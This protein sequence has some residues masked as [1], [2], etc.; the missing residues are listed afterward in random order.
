MKFSPRKAICRFAFAALLAS[1]GHAAPADC[2]SG[3]TC[4]AADLA[5]ADEAVK[6]TNAQLDAVLPPAGRVKL[7]AAQARFFRRRAHVCRQHGGGMDDSCAVRLTRARLAVLNSQAAAPV[8]PVGDAGGVDSPYN[9][10]NGP[11]GGDPYPIRLGAL[12]GAF[13]D[14]VGVLASAPFV[15]DDGPDLKLIPP[16]ATQLQ[17]GLNDDFAADH[18]GGLVISVI[19][20]PGGARRLHGC[21]V[22]GGAVGPVCQNYPAWKSGLWRPPPGSGALHVLAVG[23]GGGGGMANP[24]TGVGGA[25]GGSGK[26]ITGTMP[27]PDGP[28]RIVVG[29]GGAGARSAKAGSM[30]GTGSVIGTLVARGGWGGQPGCGGSADGPGGNSGGGGGGGGTYQ[31]SYDAG[32]GGMGGTGGDGGAGLPPTDI[33]AGFNGSDGGAGTAFPIFDFSDLTFG[34]GPGGAGGSFG[35]GGLT[36]SG[37]SCAGGGGG[38]GGGGGL[39]IN[40]AGPH[41][42]SGTGPELLKLCGAPALN[43]Q[44][45]LG[46]GAGGGGAGAGVAGPAGNGANGVVVVEW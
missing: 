13:A 32:A 23:G 7:R 24:A 28:M 12:V 29:Q 39:L 31:T 18:T 34:A 38:G 22:F 9:N 36:A 10:A 33:L 19:P 2:L 25:G 26:V 42:A 20:A 35:A 37:A 8:T 45:G 46:Y 43:G 41:A 3:G 6:Q 1:L 21:A 14:T 16:G 17:L 15:L 5:Q 11:P 4:A 30:G 27:I 40:N 44:G